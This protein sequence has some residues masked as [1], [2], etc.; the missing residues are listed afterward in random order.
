M[1]TEKGENTLSAQVTRMMPTMVDEVYE[2]GISSPQLQ[3]GTEAPQMYSKEALLRAIKDPDHI[4]LVAVDKDKLVG[5]SITGIDKALRDAEI[6][7]FVVRAEY[8]RTGIGN[9][10][11]E[12]TLRTLEETTE[13]NHVVSHV[14]IDNSTMKEFLQ[15]RNFQRG[16]DFTWMEVMLPRRENNQ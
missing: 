10:L 3:T 11:L 9:Q 14:Q 4:M 2:L 7:E 16:G 6:H 15:K 8:R 1:A 12:E 5:F 13:V